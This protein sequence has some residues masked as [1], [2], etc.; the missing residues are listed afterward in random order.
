MA[1]TGGEELIVA[2]P[3]QNGKRQSAGD[4][5][6][7]KGLCASVSPSALGLIGT[8]IYSS[9]V[10]VPTSLIGHHSELGQPVRKRYSSIYNVI[11]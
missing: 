6:G 4:E 9:R 1:G 3:N 10:Q 8:Y 5:E 2:W 7:V 11:G